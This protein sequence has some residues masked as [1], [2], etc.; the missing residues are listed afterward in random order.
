M[1]SRQ[2][3]ID[4]KYLKLDKFELQTHQRGGANGTRRS[5][6]LDEVRKVDKGQIK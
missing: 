4:A 5:E 1:L 2:M 3:E 6:F